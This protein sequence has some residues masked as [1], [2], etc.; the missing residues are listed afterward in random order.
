M[1]HLINAAA[2][3][4]PQIVYAVISLLGIGIVWEKH[5]KPQ[6][7]PHNIFT[8]LTATAIAWALLIF[9]GFFR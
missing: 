8:T 7:R 1:D 6:E 9:G 3:H 5:G 2:W 4:W